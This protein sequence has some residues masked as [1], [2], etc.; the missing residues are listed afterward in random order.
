[1]TSP[2]RDAL[3][4]PVDYVLR[5]GAERQRLRISSR[6]RPY[7]RRVVRG[8]VPW[9]SHYREAHERQSQHL[10]TTNPIMLL[11]QEAWVTRWDL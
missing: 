5:D 8:P 7:P 4:S 1:M 9:S 11:L 10:F 3:P 6:P 2:L